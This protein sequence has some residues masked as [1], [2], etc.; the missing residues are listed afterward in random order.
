MTQYRAPV[1]E[2]RFVIQEVLKVSDVL[3]FQSFKGLDPAVVDA[4]L[5]EAA[6]FSEEKLAPLNHSGDQEAAHYKEGAVTMPAGFAG[7]YQAFALNGWNGLPFDPAYG[8][9]GLP[10]MVSVMV[11]E[12]MHGAN[13]A[14]GL[15]PLLTQGA[16]EL[17][18]HYGTQEQKTTYLHHLVSG[19]WT[20]T[21]CLTEPQAGSDLGAI[22]MQAVPQ[23]GNYLLKGQKMFITYGEHDMAEN[24]IHM[25]LARLPGASAG[26]KGIS[27]F[28][29][30]KYLQDGTRNDVRALS[31]EHKM[32]IHA[33]PT[34][35]MAFGEQDKCVGYL[36]GEPH[37]GLKYMFAMMNHARLSVG[38]EAIGV[39]QYAFQLASDHAAERKQMG[40]P[41]ASYPDVQRMLLTI[42]SQLEAMRALA[43]FTAKAMDSAKH[44]P[45]ESERVHHEALVSFLIP[46]V[47]G[48]ATQVG[49]DCCSEA[50]QV[51]GG[52]G[53]TEDMPVAQCLRDIRITMIYEGTNGIQAH[54]LVMRKLQLQDGLVVKVTLAEMERLMR[55][56]T[57]P[58]LAEAFKQFKEATKYMQQL[59]QNNQG[60][61]QALAAYYL[62]LCGIIWGGIMLSLEESF[63]GVSQTLS[64]E[65]IQ[66][67]QETITF[68]MRYLLPPV[69]Y[70]CD[71]LK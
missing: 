52:I 62:K 7:A 30:P 4:V 15:C 51:L 8:G 37:Q 34:C 9:Q 29:V 60:R 47:K 43:C 16:V 2:M 54:D 57:F 6:V 22:S 5:K 50:M 24:I 67:K 63:L 14:F 45:D 69:A 26:S 42:G 56:N 18:S 59:S 58:E 27:L 71:F 33:S 32:G 68:Y 20:G 25:V 55:G 65:N 19:K 23:E 12:M 17:L 3:E 35:L 64:R 70:L 1:D 38:V 66:T 13:M 61:A 44:H 39:A 46:V 31:I 28:I 41:I 53:Y 36:V 49:F 48:H 21:M 40:K 11:S 10:W